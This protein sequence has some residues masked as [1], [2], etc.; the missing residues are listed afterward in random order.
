MTTCLKIVTN[1]KEWFF[2]G[3]LVWNALHVCTEQCEAI[4]TSE[5][6]RSELS[7]SVSFVDGILLMENRN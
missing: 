2:I 6:L 7:I 5:E 1:L 3:R 4:V